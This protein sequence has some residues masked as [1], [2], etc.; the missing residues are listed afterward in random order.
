MWEDQTHATK[1]RRMINNQVATRA[2]RTVRTAH[3]F[4]RLHAE[5][6]AEITGAAWKLWAEKVGLKVLPPAQ[7]DRVLI[8]FV[9]TYLA[10]QGRILFVD[11]TTP[12][13]P[14]LSQEWHNELVR[15][16]AAE[17]DDAFVTEMQADPAPSPGR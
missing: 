2:A 14:G 10:G 6:N 8:R 1:G 7:H 3:E 5:T 17:L 11:S 4:A 16:L 12:P 13:L 15:G 9:L